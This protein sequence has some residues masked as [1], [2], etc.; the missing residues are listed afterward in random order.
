MENKTKRLPDGELN[1]RIARLRIKSKSCQMEAKI[2]N[3]KNITV[4]NDFKKNRIA[5]V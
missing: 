5:S 4:G 1:Q 3:K 2:P